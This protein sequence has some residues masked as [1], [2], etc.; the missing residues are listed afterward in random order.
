M[1]NMIIEKGYKILILEGDCTSRLYFY[2]LM[3][4]YG[5]VHITVN[6]KE[7]VYATSAVLDSSEPLMVQR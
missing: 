6:G 2:K 5:S 7:F 1:I 3:G 4:K